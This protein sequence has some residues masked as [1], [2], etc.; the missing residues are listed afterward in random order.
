MR[1]GK[2]AARKAAACKPV[3][4]RRNIFKFAVLIAHIQLYN[5]GDALQKLFFRKEQLFT[6]VIGKVAQYVGE[7][8]AAA[9]VFK[10]FLLFHRGYPVRG[11]SEHVRFVVQHVLP[12][13]FRCGGERYVRFAEHGQREGVG[14]RQQHLTLFGAAG[15]HDGLIQLIPLHELRVLDVVIERQEKPGF[16]RFFG[17]TEQR[18]DI[19]CHVIDAAVAG[20]DEHIRT[21]AGHDLGADAVERRFALCAFAGEVFKR[22][23]FRPAEAFYGVHQ[24]IKRVFRGL[25][26]RVAGAVL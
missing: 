16:H 10:I 14:H 19:C 8:R 4:I 13:G 15:R 3:V 11:S 9:L 20:D 6:A 24:V 18:F 17:H 22:Y 26:L 23:V 7:Q 1:I 12:C 2:V 25:A 5:V 21:A